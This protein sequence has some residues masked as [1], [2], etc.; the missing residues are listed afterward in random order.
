MYASKEVL[1][2]STCKGTD[3][4]ELHNLGSYT[5][6]FMIQYMYTCEYMYTK[7]YKQEILSA[8]TR[9]GTNIRK[10]CTTSFYIQECL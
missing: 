1:S 7:R 4:F 2:V 3:G 10:F 6:V 8:S 9:K 5:K